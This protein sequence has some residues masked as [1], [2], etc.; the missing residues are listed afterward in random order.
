LNKYI[1]IRIK[2]AL[3]EFELAEKFMDNDLYRN[4]AGKAFQ[5]WKATL[6]VLA[7]NSR[8]ELAK[9]FRG[10]VRLRERISVEMVDFIIAVMPTTRMKKIAALLRPKYGSDIILLTEL[11]L[12]LHEVQYNGLDKSAV[13]SRYLDLDMVKQDIGTIIEGGRRLISSITEHTEI[14][15]V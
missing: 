8:D 5:G 11:A 14:S 9:E 1:E 7:A 10:L 13:L 4:A 12:D 2:E 3:Y 15:L 6:S